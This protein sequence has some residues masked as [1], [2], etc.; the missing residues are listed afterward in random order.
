[1][2]SVRQVVCAQGFDGWCHKLYSLTF[3]VAVKIMP[4]KSV[5][6]GK[7]RFCL[8][9]SEDTSCNGGKGMVA[10]EVSPKQQE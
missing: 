5:N 7:I 4:D 6:E 10:G 2:G 8:V 3:L 1:M 9:A